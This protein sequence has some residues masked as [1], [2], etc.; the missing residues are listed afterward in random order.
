MRA[1]NALVFALLSLLS[2]ANAY[3][4]IMAALG[5]DPHQ[6]QKRQAGSWSQSQRVDVS[7][8][9][10]Y[11]PPGPNDRRGPCPGLNALANQ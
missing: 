4:S 9:H 7:G 6:G 8:T 5:N 10:A 3:P 11:A 2:G 1:G